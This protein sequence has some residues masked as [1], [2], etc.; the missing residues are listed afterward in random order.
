MA[1]EPVVIVGAGLAG[2]SAAYHLRQYGMASLLYDKEDR[3]G[4]HTR[5]HAHEGFIFDEGPHVSFTKDAY[6]QEL[7]AKS[8]GTYHEFLSTQLNYYHGAWLKH[9]ALCHLHGLPVETVERCLVDF[10]EAQRRS[11]PAPTDYD[12]WLR[13]HCGSYF[14]EQFAARYTRKYWTVEPAE[15]TTD[16]VGARVY[17]PRIEE[18]VRGALQP[19]AQALHYIQRCRYP[20]AGGY[21]AYTRL[22]QEGAEVRTGCALAELD[23][24]RHRALFANG[25]AITYGSLV[26]TLPLP[27]L[28][29]MMTDAPR[30]VRAAADRLRWTSVALV[31]VGVRRAELSGAHWLYFYDEDLIFSRVSFPHRLSPQNAPPGCGSLQAEI[32]YSRSRPLPTR[33]VLERTLEDLR[34]VGLLRADDELVVTATQ[35]IAFANVI[36]DHAREEAVR[37]VHRFLRAHGILPCGRYGEWGYLWS[38]Q[39][40]LSGRR[41][42]EELAGSAVSSTVVSGGSRNREA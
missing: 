40:V 14:T 18:V 6:V 13:Q 27:V 28:V 39:A 10:F 7:F 22:L 5:S 23:V 35:E 26:A 9:P 41:I 19:Q 25:Q 4:G 33:Q 3:A 21:E 38:D 8:A 11:H 42:A 32:Y 20:A 29:Q 36:F 2:L 15:L 37:C 34:R 30:D 1:E 31:N 24:R 16:W 12:Q 17:A